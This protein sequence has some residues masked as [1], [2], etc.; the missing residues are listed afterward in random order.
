MI[1]VG[2]LLTDKD[3]R[4]FATYAR[5]NYDRWTG[6]FLVHQ[7]VNF[8]RY[9]NGSIFLCEDLEEGEIWG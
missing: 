9:F 4:Q 8:L 2:V 1:G 7:F 3:F 6:Y 5:W